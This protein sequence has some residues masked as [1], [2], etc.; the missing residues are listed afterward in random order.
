MAFAKV[1]RLSY[2]VV[3]LGEWRANVCRELPFISIVEDGNRFGPGDRDT[4]RCRR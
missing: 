4:V 2:A 3:R 1:P